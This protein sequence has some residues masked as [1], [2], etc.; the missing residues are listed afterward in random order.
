MKQGNKQDN[1]QEALPIISSSA[2]ADAVQS[3]WVACAQATTNQALHR[4]LKQH[5]EALAIQSIVVAVLLDTVKGADPAG[6]DPVPHP[7]PAPW[8]N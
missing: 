1:K 4:A 5:Q 6:N 2:T 8:D 3:T 7:T